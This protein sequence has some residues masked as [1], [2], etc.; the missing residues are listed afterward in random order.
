MA[1]IISER[2]SIYVPAK[3]MI[4]SA[5]YDKTIHKV[6]LT[7]L[8]SGT[9]GFNEIINKITRKV[10]ASLFES[11]R[12]ASISFELAELRAEED[13]EIESWEYVFVKVKL[14]VDERVFNA[15]C[16]LL[17]AEAYSKVTADD[18]V[19]VL[20]VLEHV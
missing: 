6:K 15:L 11:L 20:L 14:D 18:A 13:T 17:I 19:K 16:D 1:L 5:D 12:A 4:V 8:V 10:L 2:P 7:D 9:N 3:E